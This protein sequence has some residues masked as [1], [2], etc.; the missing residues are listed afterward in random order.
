MNEHYQICL[1][2]TG[3]LFALANQV[4]EEEKLPDIRLKVISCAFTEIANVVRAEEAAGCEAFVSG[5]AY[6]AEISRVS[7][8]PVSEIHISDFDYVA[9]MQNAFALG[10]KPVIYTYRFSAPPNLA[11]ISGVFGFAVD[12]VVFDD[13]IALYD[14]IRSSD[15]DVVIS[16]SLGCGYARSLGKKYVLSYA[17]TDSVYQ[18]ILFARD[19]AYE[20]R[21]NNEQNARLIA[22]GDLSPIGVILSNQDDE[23]EYLNPVAREYTHI[24]QQSLQSSSMRD[25]LPNF[26]TR[27][28]LTGKLQETRSYRILFGVRYR[29]IQKKLQLSGGRSSVCTFIQIDNRSARQKEERSDSTGKLARWDTLIHASP[30]FEKLEARG[31][32]EA[33]SS[34][35]LL[36]EGEAGTEKQ[37]VAECIHTG[38]PRADAPCLC[39]NLA[40]LPEQEAGRQLFG[41]TGPEGSFPGLL[42]RAN[43]GT[44]ILEALSLADRRVQACL[45]DAVSRR[46]ITRVGELHSRPLNLRFITLGEP[47]LSARANPEL[48]LRLSTSVLTVPP[49]REHAQ[50]AFLQFQHFFR[51]HAQARH[52]SCEAVSRTLSFYDW[53]GNNT[54]LSVVCTRVRDFARERPIVSDSIAQ[55]AVIGAIGEDALFRC[56]LRRC[57][58]LSDIRGADPAVLSAAIN[59]AKQILHYN[60]TQLCEKLGIHR[61]TLWRLLNSECGIPRVPVS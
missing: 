34:S 28:F 44:V 54:E 5:S 45:L 3:D 55:A 33:Y 2:A 16:G 14:S 60:N 19:I 23:I 30:V 25:L 42:E 56:V 51:G 18:A 43:G 58:E 48:L 17:G 40:G 20:L 12:H 21:R 53:P 49:L 59:T 57:P 52:L 10:K 15:Y 41:Y 46:E 27:A 13:E 29:V 36:L 9:A 37:A 38:G 39:L 35:P 22:I 1:I 7:R 8:V 32:Q 26:D 11:R 47:E 6:A 50:D 24:T 31:R 4:K 61:S